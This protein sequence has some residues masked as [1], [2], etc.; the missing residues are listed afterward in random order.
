MSSLSP[1]APAKLNLSILE[2]LLPG[3]TLVLNGATSPTGSTSAGPGAKTEPK[4]PSLSAR[5]HHSTAAA[6]TPTVVEPL[7]DIPDELPGGWNDLEKEGERFVW[8]GKPIIDSAD[9]PETI[10]QQAEEDLGR[11]ECFTSMDHQIVKQAE[12]RTRLVPVSRGMLYVELDAASFYLSS[13][14]LPRNAKAASTRTLKDGTRVE[15]SKKVTNGRATEKIVRRT[16]DNVVV[17]E[18]TTEK[19]VS[20]QCMI[21]DTPPRWLV[22]ALDDRGEHPALRVLRGVRRCPYGRRDATLVTEPGYDALSE[23]IYAPMRAV[24]LPADLSPEAARRHMQ[25]VLE[26]FSDFPL[27][28]EGR[29]AVLAFMITIVMRPALGKAPMFGFD[30]SVRGSGKGLLVQVASLIASGAS[31]MLV[32]CRGREEEMEKT[33]VAA[34]R[35]GAVVTQLD[36]ASAP[37]GGGTLD[38]ILTSDRE[39]WIR[40][41]GSSD[42]ELVSTET[43]IA[44]TGNGLTFVGDTN[45]RVIPIRLEPDVERPEERADFR[46]PDLLA[47]V[48]ERAA[49]LNTSLLAIPEAYRLAGRPRSTLPPLGS[50]ETFS[51]L[52]RDCVLWLGLPDPCAGRVG[53]NEQDPDRVFL[54][55]LLPAIEAADKE[56]CGLTALAISSLQGAAPVFDEFK[57]LAGRMNVKRLGRRLRIFVGRIVDGRKLAIPKTANGMCRW[58]VERVGAPPSTAI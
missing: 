14:P 26:P 7:A 30:A 33:L 12:D 48:Q 4:G 54:S 31:P 19:D 38:A 58:R 52:V 20:T 56:R 35:C 25:D 9:S 47:N 29:A 15:R 53:L 13:P 1:S 32:P 3:E 45:R 46:Y 51:H 17:E 55:V 57:D 49:A 50:F 2:A 22:D 5:P 11:R 28:A 36:N 8:K 16:K 18:G 27:S 41:L 6:A 34:L 39:A 42:M 40:L 37:I 44:V 24:A 43:T 23:Y 21:K 10:L